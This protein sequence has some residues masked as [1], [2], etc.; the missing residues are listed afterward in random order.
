MGLGRE[1]QRLNGDR[2]TP[3][4]RH[5]T[6]PCVPAVPGY[7]PCIPT[8][9]GYL[10]YKVGGQLEEG[11]ACKRDFVGRRSRASRMVTLLLLLLLQM[12]TLLLLLL[13]Q[14]V[15]LP[16]LLRGWSLCYYC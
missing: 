5:T 13:L 7:H 14:M 4:R 12:V 11:L 15:T 10:A 16:L 1:K 6:H 8:V 3:Q 2:P 9:Q